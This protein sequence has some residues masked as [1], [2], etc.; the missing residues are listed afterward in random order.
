M[1]K[2]VKQEL[3]DIKGKMMYLEDKFKELEVLVK[4]SYDKI[5]AE[6]DHLSRFT[7]AINCRTNV[8]RELIE[9][10]KQLIV[11]I[12]KLVAQM[13]RRKRRWLW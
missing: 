1:V 3:R 6:L 7:E 4:T 9:T 12:D 13:E 10:I 8:E 11:R 5:M 2:D